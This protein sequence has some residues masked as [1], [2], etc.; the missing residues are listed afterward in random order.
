M[1]GRTGPIVSI[2]AI[3]VSTAAWADTVSLVP[4]LT[5]A[6]PLHPV[7]LSVELDASGS[8][9]GLQFALSFPSSSVQVDS[10]TAAGGALGFSGIDAETGSGQLSGIVFDALG[11]G[12]IA[13]GIGP[14]VDIHLRL[15][16][17]V[18]DTVRF[19]VEDAVVADAAYQKVVPGLQGTE[20]V[21]ATSLAVDDPP[22]P[23]ARTPMSFAL[24]PARPNPMRGQ[25]TIEYELPSAVD[26]R[27]RVYDLAGRLV[28]TLVDGRRE[29]G[30][31]TAGWDGRNEG[32]QRVRAGVYFYRIN[33]GPF[34]ATRPLVV[35]Q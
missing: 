15:D 34:S 16:G 9:A 18:G 20:I 3:C 10:V 11:S 17:A 35:L 31:W 6:P 33:A 21:L 23:R 2:L 24:L 19:D 12:T 8:R 22:L 7:V 14:V 27:L 1:P 13:A 25:I 28:R 5:A 4:D 26:V 32:A 29:A 30:H